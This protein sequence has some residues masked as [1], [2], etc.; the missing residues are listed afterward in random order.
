MLAG[1]RYQSTPSV[2]TLGSVVTA[3]SVFMVSLISVTKWAR[4]LPALPVKQRPIS[5][6]QVIG[7]DQVEASSTDRK[8]N[9]SAKSGAK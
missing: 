8:T 4:R 5:L 3:Y 2:R 7:F 1:F 9:T 6:T